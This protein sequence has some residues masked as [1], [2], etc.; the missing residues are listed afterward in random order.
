LT[1]AGD[2]LYRPCAL[3]TALFS[4]GAPI[5]SRLFPPRR[6]AL[7][8]ILLPLAVATCV[9]S[10]AA[11]ADEP[12]V[13]MSVESLAERWAAPGTPGYVDDYD[14][15]T[16]LP[17]AFLG[18]VAG[19]VRLRDRQ[20][21]TMAPW[22]GIDELQPT[23]AW[24][25]SVAIVTGERAGWTGFGA[26]LVDLRT[27]ATPPSGGHP[28]AAFTVVNGSSG[29]NR[30]GLRL[31]HGNADVWLRGGAL[32][33]ER[34]GTG[35]LGRRGDHVWFF[36]GSRTRGAH[37][38]AASYAQRGGTNTTRRNADNVDNDT[39]TRPPWAG[40]EEA[41]RGESGNASWTIA[42]GDRQ[43]TLRLARS[44]DH[45]ESFESP[46]TS[47]LFFF[48]EREAQQNT[49]GIEAASGTDERGHGLRFEYARTR[50]FRSADALSGQ[51]DNRAV[52]TRT[53]WLAA[54]ATRPF[55][56]GRLEAQAGV[57]HVSSMAKTSELVQGSP[58]V[59]WRT[60]TDQRRLRL[61][62]ERVVT[63]VWS[64]L[65]PQV[66]PFAQDVWMGG[67]ELG[68]GNRDQRWVEV[69]GLGATIGNG[70]RLT[71]WPVRDISLRYGWTVDPQRTTDLM[72]T[73]AGGFRRGRFGIDGSA[74][75]RRRPRTGF[76]AQVDPA[77]GARAGTDASFRLFT[78]D[79][80]VRIRLEGAWVGPRENESLPEY[81]QAP[82]ALP[83]FV[84]FGG[85]LGLTL[86]D[87]RIALTTRRI[88]DQ[89]RPQ[90]WTDPSSPF[91]GTPATGSGRQYRM[92]LAWPLFN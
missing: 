22:P 89:P 72:V 47:A 50:V 53:L 74:F 37:T 15:G 28:R 14:M 33:E 38:I 61:Y 27:F 90:I 17:L 80:G 73:A 59:V 19:G 45:R 41:A 91:P 30:T 4:K 58:S 48:S 7:A 65:A 83:G 70:A 67:G 66:A 11:F 20:V 9:L 43:V 49:A 3:A 26:S 34:E 57:G 81:F 40:F 78:G 71:R 51:F 56:G 44:H 36:D 8:R 31:E 62:A 18:V 64:D 2:D 63:P 52:I 87:A 88:E 10:R 42:H 79:L 85:S 23:L 12:P 24:S 92:E 6:T 86:G 21:A 35:L 16:G 84:T 29:V 39:F 54:R 25:D 82:R 69:G 77:V 32:S 5:S 76:T 68:L 46:T 55:L 13:S 1:P 60:G 75:A